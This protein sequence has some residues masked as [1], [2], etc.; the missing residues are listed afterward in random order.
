MSAARRVL[1]R[2]LD[3]TL[4]LLMVVSVGN[5]CWQIFARF[6]LA[7]PSAVTD[8]LARGLLIW[9][10][11][12]GAARAMGATAHLSIEALP[13]RLEAPVRARLAR[14]RD[15]VILL[16]SLVVLGFG[17]L[18]LVWLTLELDQLSAALG[19]PLAVFYAAAPLS[20]VAM[21]FYA[22]CS[23]LGAGDEADA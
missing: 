20:G 23:L 5:V 13:D 6:V 10:G 14:V 17:G 4:A 15:A 12:L 21:A 16:F 11:L 8:E 1:D 22:L 2:L 7:S 19:I 18:R 9:V 3:G